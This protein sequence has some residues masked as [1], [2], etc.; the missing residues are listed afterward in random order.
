MSDQKHTSKNNTFD[1]EGNITPTDI[2]GFEYK[3]VF[4]P[5]EPLNDMPKR[6]EQRIR[7]IRKLRK[8]NIFS[9]PYIASNNTND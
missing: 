3:K 5:S 9:H 7:L 8:K 4:S 1:F 2:F 6:M